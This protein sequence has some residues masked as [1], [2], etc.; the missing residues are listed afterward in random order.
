MELTWTREYSCDFPEEEIDTICNAA[1]IGS[2]HIDEQ[3]ILRMIDSVVCGF[4]DDIY[5]AWDHD[6]SMKVLDVIKQRIGGVQ[7]SMFDS[8]D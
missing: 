5:Y 8:D 1:R 6:L 4:E 3:D 7:L 2:N